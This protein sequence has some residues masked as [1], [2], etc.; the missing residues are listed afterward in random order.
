MR[1]C[2]KRYNSLTDQTRIVINATTTLEQY[3]I[4]L[5]ICT[6]IPSQFGEVHIPTVTEN[7]IMYW[8]HK[9]A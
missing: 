6:K 3:A 1:E 7:R 4:H 5:I 8:Q 9:G 2:G